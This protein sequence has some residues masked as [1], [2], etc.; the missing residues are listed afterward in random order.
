MDV[1]VTGY[2]GARGTAI[3]AQEYETDLLK[4]Y[5]E[6]LVERAKNFSEEFGECNISDASVINSLNAEYAESYTEF[7]IF[8]A[9]FQMSKSLKCGLRINI[10]DIPIRQETIEI[11]EELS[12]NPYALYSGNSMIIVCTNSGEVINRLADSN[13]KATLV[14]YTTCEDNDKILINGDERSFLQHIRKDELKNK[15]GRKMYYERTDSVNC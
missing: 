13:I 11:C 7:G 14:G 10:K 5:P 12:V 15:L 3:L 9:L 4:R 8:E 1:L 6:W 2:I